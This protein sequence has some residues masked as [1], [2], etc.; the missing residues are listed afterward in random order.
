MTGYLN[1]EEALGLIEKAGEI[2]KQ[3]FSS[4]EEFGKNY[5]VGY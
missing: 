3:N 5:A 2:I 1:R 4:W